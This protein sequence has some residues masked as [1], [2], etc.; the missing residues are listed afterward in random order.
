MGT[1][2]TVKARPYYKRTLVVNCSRQI[3]LMAG[4]FTGTVS[5]C[6]K[7]VFVMPGVYDAP[8]VQTQWTY[9]SPIVLCVAPC[10]GHLAFQTH[11]FQCGLLVYDV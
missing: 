1:G 6:G 3:C 10:Q 9:C 2:K 8:V 11:V 5:Q 4:I 7:F